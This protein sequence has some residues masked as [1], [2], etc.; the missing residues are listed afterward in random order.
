MK[1]LCCFMIG[2]CLTGFVWIYGMITPFGSLVI[3][4]LKLMERSTFFFGAI[5]AGMIGGISLVEKKFDQCITGVWLGSASAG[6]L[7]GLFTIISIN[8]VYSAIGGYF[9]AVTIIYGCI[10]LLSQLRIGQQ[11]KVEVSNFRWKRGL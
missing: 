10:A 5:A 8:P 9:L 6:L 4:D 1:F 11:I 3:G 7:L 2:I